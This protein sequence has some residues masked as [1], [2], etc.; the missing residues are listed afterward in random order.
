MSNKNFVLILIFLILSCGLVGFWQFKKFGQALQ[1]V[2]L[3]EIELPETKLESFLPSEQGG[4]KEWT[5]P[6][7]KLKLEYS[8]NWVESDQIL[9]EQFN[10]EGVVLEEAKI[11]FFAYRF[12]F[13]DQALAFLMVEEISPE[14]SLDELVEDIEKNIIG[15]DGEIEIIDLKE[16]KETAWLEIKFKR[17]SELDFRAKE[18]FVFSK[19]KTYLI[20]FSALEKDWTK[21]EGEGK[22]ILDSAQLIL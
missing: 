6:D 8:A 21:F 19:D 10:Q 22:E 14:K 18:K 4:I 13:E 2:G 7:G 20:A 1:G 16:E 11:L 17:E 12:Q 3:P 15:Q 5:S 9:L